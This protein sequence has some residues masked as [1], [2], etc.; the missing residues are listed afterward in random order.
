V[1][2]APRAAIVWR[3]WRTQSENCNDTALFGV[4]VAAFRCSHV[5]C[6]TAS[7]ITAQVHFSGR[8]RLNNTPALS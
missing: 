3:Q 6:V 2:F 8:R 7:G 5:G 4:T 1:S